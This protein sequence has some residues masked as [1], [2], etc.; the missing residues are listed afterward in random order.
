MLAQPGVSQRRLVLLACVASPSRAAGR[1]CLGAIGV[2][3]YMKL[4]INAEYA[5]CLNPPR[6]KHSE[7]PI[8]LRWRL[9]ASG[10]RIHVVSWLGDYRITLHPSC[11]IAECTWTENVYYVYSC[12]IGSNLTRSAVSRTASFV[13]SRPQKSS[14]HAT[15]VGTGFAATLRLHRGLCA[16]VLS[17]R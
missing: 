14:L 2:C 7:S 9:S 4:A 3:L 8:F 6:Q 16:L 11:P 13:Q 1:H 10:R 17:N 5:H 12:L 15:C